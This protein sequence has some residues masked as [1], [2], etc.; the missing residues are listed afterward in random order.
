MT[1]PKILGGFLSTLLVCGLRVAPPV[2]LVATAFDS[3]PAVANRETSKLIEKELK[4]HA[5]LEGRIQRGL[6]LA[7]ASDDAAAAARW[8]KKLAKEKERHDAEMLRLT[9]G[10]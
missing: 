6:S 10:T 5:R 2:V 1:M 9:R 3:A 4:R 8:E 7:H